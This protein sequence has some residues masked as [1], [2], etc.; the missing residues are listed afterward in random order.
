M[1]AEVLAIMWVG[2]A[3]DGDG[4][5]GSFGSFLSEERTNDIPAKYIVKPKILNVGEKS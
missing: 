4:S 5:G 2:T 1:S 3:H